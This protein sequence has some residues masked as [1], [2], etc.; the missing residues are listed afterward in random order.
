M[1]GGEPA[2]TATLSAADA[3]P[4]RLLHTL[5]LGLGLRVAFSI[6]P[7]PPHE[8]DDSLLGRLPFG[9]LPG[10]AAGRKCPGPAPDR[11][12]SGAPEPAWPV[13]GTSPGSSLPPT[14]RARMP[15]VSALTPQRTAP[16]SPAPY[17]AASAPRGSGSSAGLACPGSARAFGLAPLARPA[18]S[19]NHWPSG[20]RRSA[21]SSPSTARFCADA[22]CENEAHMG[23][24]T[25]VHTP[26][27]SAQPPHWPPPPRV[28]AKRP[29]QTSVALRRASSTCTQSDWAGDNVLHAARGN[30]PGVALMCS[31]SCRCAP[32]QGQWQ[33]LQ[34]VPHVCCIVHAQQHRGQESP[35]P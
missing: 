30:G 7:G 34:T 31:D 21:T 13:P 32:E 2:R 28:C 15:C 24:Q 19:S 4:D 22:P 6:A 20:N 25:L 11:H 26:A 18:R 12:P 23:S 9:V 35:K 1:G 3:A 16:R 14:C 8:L 27:A 17:P 33:D 10:S 5:W 29:A